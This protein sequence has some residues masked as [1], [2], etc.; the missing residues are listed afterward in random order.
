MKS[1]YRYTNY[2]QFLEDVKVDLKITYQ[3]FAE[4]CGVSSNA[5]L[6]DIIMAD[7]KMTF[8]RA[9]RLGNA[10]RMPHAEILFLL[11]LIGHNDSK[12]D[13]DEVFYIE[14]K[15]TALEEIVNQVSIDSK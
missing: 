9:I 15:N 10:L 14:M 7:K 3:E 6:I 11:A 12:D 4:K 13:E 8:Y 5:F 2:R 1:V